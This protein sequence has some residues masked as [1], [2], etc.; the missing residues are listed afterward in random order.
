MGGGA[1]AGEPASPKPL[2]L[3]GPWYT[4]SRWALYWLDMNLE[5]T[6]WPLLASNHAALSAT[7]PAWLT[8]QRGALAATAGAFSADSLAAEGAVSVDFLGTPSAV[9]PPGTVG[10]LP[11]LAHS[12]WLHARMTANG[13]AMRVDVY[14]LLRG[15][16]NRYLHMLITDG[17]TGTLHLPV[18]A[19]PEYSLKGNDTSFDLALLRW[20]AAELLLLAAELGIAEPLA[21]NYS[22]VLARLAPLPTNADGIMVAAG[23]P[24]AIP[25]RHW[26]HLFAIWPLRTLDWRTAD[27]PGRALIEASVDH[28]AGLT[29]QQWQPRFGPGGAPAGGSYVWECPNG[30]TGDGI[31]GLSAHIGRPDA[32]V[33]NLSATLATLIPPNTL[34]GEENES[35]NI[36][37]AVAVAHVLHEL[38]LQTDPDG[39][40]GGGATVRVFPAVPSNWS[41][42]AF[43]R[44]SAAGVLV[45]AARAS[46][47]TLWVHA[48]GA[49]AAGASG[50]AGSITLVIDGLRAGAPLNVTTVPRGLAWAQVGPGAISVP[51]LAPDQEVLVRAAQAA[52]QP[53]PSVAAVPNDASE[54]NGWGWHSPPTGPR[55]SAPPFVDLR[56]VLPD[57]YAPPMS[58]SPPG[59]GRRVAATTPGWPAAVYHAVYLPPEWSNAS[60]ARLPLIV[61][62]AGNGPWQS[63][64]GDVS[65]GRPEGSNLGFGITAGAGAVWLSLPML[66]AAGDFVET[67]WWGCPATAPFSGEPPTTTGQGAGHCG[68]A[69][70]VTAAVRYLAET[71]R[72]AADAY[73][74]DP[75]RVVIAGFSRGAVGVNYLGLNNDD[76][77]SLWRASIAYAHYDGQPMDEDDP[78]PNPGPPASYERLRRLGQRPQYIVAELDGAFSETQPYINASGVAVNA[79]FAE[80]GY[81]NHN[82]AWTLRPS[83]QRD[84][85]RAWFW[86][87]VA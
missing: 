80:T 76:I 29:C 4:H 37:S 72:Y 55:C 17:A 25:H 69:C 68:A 3:F 8:A 11:W 85:L 7:L 74:T 40:A 58:T 5:L 15:A 73:H 87:V 26:S 79:T 2:D 66:T 47:A 53:P 83:P 30:F 36:E 78:F 21:A 50:R 67:W 38:L 14:P 24:F 20:G 35:P 1:G 23:V 42:V 82:D 22:A 44:L 57:L 65:M 28:Y 64:F 61:E 39:A 71:V 32:A 16:V 43:W 27:A 46:N 49:A 77:A 51:A 60:D 9:A 56:S 33:G 18:T 6:Y 75:A 84:E 81:C 10:C 12:A 31:A 52:P 86:S 19:S 45:S 13:T 63:P 54:Y 41:D 62:L 34:Y 59:P 48:Q 70:N